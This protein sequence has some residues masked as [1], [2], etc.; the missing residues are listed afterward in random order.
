MIDDN[1]D[2][3]EDKHPALVALVPHICDALR[4]A[5][6]P[7][8]WGLDAWGAGE[9]GGAESGSGMDE[10]AGGGGAGGNRQGLTLAPFS[11]QPEPLL[12]HKMHLND[13]WTPR[14]HALHT[15][16]TPINTP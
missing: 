16:V 12:S 13:P 7:Q 1:A 11:A 8:A 5:W 6:L 14:Y 3:E 2:E 4:R 9:G 10:G 15:P